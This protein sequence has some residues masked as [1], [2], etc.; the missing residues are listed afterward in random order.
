MKSS[1]YISMTNHNYNY[2]KEK[3]GLGVFEIENGFIYIDDR[4]VI[5][6]NKIN[7]WHRL[8]GPAFI[9]LLDDQHYSN[10]YINDCGVTT[11]LETWAK[12]NDIDID[13]L[14]DVD[15]ALIKIVWSNY[16]K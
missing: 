8:D 9:S 11:I 16:G 7:D 12:E 6:K 14:T 3:Y 2:Y 4:A 15:K 10:W 13:N 1:G 5:F